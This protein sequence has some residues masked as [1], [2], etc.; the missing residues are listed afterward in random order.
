MRHSLPPCGVAVL[1]M[2]AAACSDDNNPTQ[3]ANPP[4][5]AD[6]MLST[7]QLDAASF[8][9]AFLGGATTVFDDTEE[10]FEQPAPNLDAAAL[11]VHEEGNEAFEEVFDEVTGVGPLF[12]NTSCEGCHIGDGR[13]RPPNPGEQIETMLFRVSIPGTDPFGG[14]KPAP[15]FGGQLQTRGI[16]GVLAEGDV[17]FTYTP[18]NGQYA[19]G[20]P[21]TLQAPTHTLINPYTPIPT[22]MLLG[23]R[24]APPVFGL[25]LLEAVPAVLL[26]A[27]S[28]PNDRDR[29]GIS[30]RVNVVYDAAAQRNAVGRF[31]LKANQ[32]N[33]R[34]QSAGAYNGDMGVTTSLFAAENCEGQLTIPQCAQHAPEVDDETLDAAAF[35]VR[36]LG[37]PARRDL[38]DLQALRGELLFLSARC[39]SCHIP[40][41]ATGTLPGVPAVSN[42]IIRPFTDLLLHDMGAQLAD[43]R[44][45]F[46][47]SGREWRTP[48]LWGI[49]LV[50][51][52]NE[53]TNFLHDGR[54]RNIEEAILWHGGEATTAR[55][56]FR[57][58]SARDRAALLK[59][60]NSL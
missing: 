52:V 18:V 4:S 29:D 35:Y 8:G 6:A 34:Q 1:L 60:L 41:I 19:D 20:T 3:A 22:G 28:D 33:L 23:P 15:G 30:G 51:T 39:S 9:R 13:G 12:H 10:A 43:N 59:F 46:L 49:G 42:Q 37:V 40:I 47:A 38:N 14:P 56:S 55:E 25:G 53:H 48:P 24:I 5:G 31:G 17:Q 16:T 58:M 26:Y 11:A 21:F 44:P 27:L 2:V 7:N 45:D 57:N 36:T 50:N 54:A 32:P